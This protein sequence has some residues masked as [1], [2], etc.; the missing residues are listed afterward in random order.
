MFTLG[1]RLGFEDQE[2]GSDLTVNVRFGSKA[3]MNRSNRDVCFTPESGLFR[4]Q[5]RFSASSRDK[6]RSPGRQSR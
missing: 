6:Q 5:R 4:P 1:C 3:D 2:A